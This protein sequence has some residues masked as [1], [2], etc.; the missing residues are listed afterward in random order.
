MLTA[1]FTFLSVICL[2]AVLVSK[3]F[4]LARQ[5]M[6][7][8][9]MLVAGLE[10]VFSTISLGLLI[11]ISITTSYAASLDSYL[12]PGALESSIYLSIGG[13]IFAIVAFFFILEV[14]VIFARDLLAS[15]SKFMPSSKRMPPQK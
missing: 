6:P 8:K 11:T 9:S 7:N 13:V 4:F 10:M 3:S 5:W 1:W 2:F 12:T 14:L 15:S